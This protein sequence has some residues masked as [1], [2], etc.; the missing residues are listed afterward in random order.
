MLHTP[1]WPP[2][3]DAEGNAPS[4]AA[5]YGGLWA[6][7]AVK[8][9]GDRLRFTLPKLPPAEPVWPDR[10]SLIELVGIADHGAKPDRLRRF[11]AKW[12]PLGGHR[13]PGCEHVAPSIQG[14][15]GVTWTTE[16]CLDCWRNLA[17]TYAGLTRL[18][19]RAKSDRIAAGKLQDRLVQLVLQQRVG[20][21]PMLGPPRV[22]F[23]TTAGL[24]GYLTIA[25]LGLWAAMDGR[26][27]PEFCA[28]CGTVFDDLDEYERSGATVQRRPRRD[29]L[30]YCPACRDAG[31][32][33][34]DAVRRYRAR[35]RRDEL[36]RK[37]D[38][39]LA[40]L[41][42]QVSAAKESA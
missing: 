14:A 35:K 2:F 24:P 29:R 30:H 10:A 19:A 25:M 4:D 8:L 17:D 21:L 3:T 36:E 9:T 32:A 41:K 7:E 12:G 22:T 5:S 11:A 16:E 18:A 42:A 6:P 1:S 20:P 38:A 28:A 23:S 34:R 37:A 26:G 31:L 39:T 13:T 40:E 33:T 15:G 27:L